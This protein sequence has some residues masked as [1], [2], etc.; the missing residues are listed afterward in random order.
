MN[1]HHS[2]FG[3]EREE[4]GERERYIIYYYIILYYITHIILSG[5]VT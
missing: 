3:E 2:D 5:G 4:R 1:E